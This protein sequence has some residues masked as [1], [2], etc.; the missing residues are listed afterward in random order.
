M[1]INSKNKG[2]EYERKVAKILGEWWGEDFKRTPMSGGLHWDKDNRV[3]GDIVPP[4]D[5]LFPFTTE[6]KK[7]ES[8]EFHLAFKSKNE[9][10]DYWTQSVGDA[11]RVNKKPMVVFSKNRQ[12][13]YLMIAHSDWVVLGEPKIPHIVLNNGNLQSRVICILDEFVE[14]VTKE[15]VI[16][17]FK[18]A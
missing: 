16:K 1:A 3:S 12:P 2:N 15:Q 13:N 18:L 8:W 17:C 7:R 14:A 6:C 10:D 5:S 9:I 11:N 4:P